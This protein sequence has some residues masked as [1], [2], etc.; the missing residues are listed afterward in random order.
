M[1]PI[2]VPPVQ[3]GRDFPCRPKHPPQCECRAHRVHKFRCTASVVFRRVIGQ[4]STGHRTAIRAPH[5]HGVTVDHCPDPATIA[6]LNEP[7]DRIDGGRPEQEQHHEN[8]IP[9]PPMT[10]RPSRRQSHRPFRCPP[11]ITTEGNDLACHHST[12]RD[13][14][15]AAS[16]RVDTNALPRLGSARRS[17]R[18]TGPQNAPGG[19]GCRSPVPA[20]RQC[21]PTDITSGTRRSVSPRSVHSAPHSTT[22]PAPRA[23]CAGQ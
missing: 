6:L 17:S 5:P 9:P 13:L 1:P 11:V 4:D 23:I 2:A 15:K 10:F 22:A 14:P 3:P 20:A 8:R 16:F 21:C 12:R 19:T 18:F 7:V